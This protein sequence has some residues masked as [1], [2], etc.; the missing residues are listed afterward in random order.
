M[1]LPDTLHPFVTTSSLTF[2]VG[3][4]NS[5]GCATN[6]SRVTRDGWWLDRVGF[7]RC[8]A[9]W[10]DNYEASRARIYGQP[11]P[12]IFKAR[13][14]H[15]SFF[16]HSKGIITTQ[17]RRE[18][19]RSHNRLQSEPAN[20]ESQIGGPFPM[21]GSGET[22]S[23]FA[24]REGHA[25]ISRDENAVDR[26]HARLQL[27]TSIYDDHLTPLPHVRIMS[28]LETHRTKA[29]KTK[30]RGRRQPVDPADYIS[31][32]H[33]ESVATMKQ[34]PPSAGSELGALK[35]QDAGRS[36]FIQT[37]AEGIPLSTGARG[38][39]NR[40]HSDTD[41]LQDLMSRG[42]KDLDHPM[43]C[44]D[45]QDNPS[46]HAQTTAPHRAAFHV[47][48]INHLNNLNGSS[49]PFSGVPSLL[50][51]FERLKHLVRERESDNLKLKQENVILKQIERRHQKDIEFLA[52]QGDDSPRVISALRDEIQGLRNKLREYF[53]N[54]INDSRHIRHLNEEVRHLR[55]TNQGLRNLVADRELGT[56]EALTRELNQTKARLAD[57]E[58]AA[59]EMGKRTELIDKNLSAENRQLRTKLHHLEDEN[60]GLRDNA[61]R[62]E[63]MI[64]D[65]DKEIAS[66]SIYRHNAVH[67]KPIVETICKQ[68]VKRD[69]DD[70]VK[71]WRK[72]IF[73][74]FPKLVP[75]FVTIFDGSK[76]E[77][78]VFLP[79]IKAGFTSA[80]QR[81]TFKADSLDG[82]A[83][84]SEKSNMG[85]ETYETLVLQWTDDPNIS[86]KLT[87][88]V[89][90]KL[91]LENKDDGG[92]LDDSGISEDSLH[93][94]RDAADG[95][96]SAVVSVMS[97][98]ADGLPSSKVVHVRN[99]QCGRHYFFGVV[100]RR[101]GVEGVPC[102]ADPVLVDKLPSQLPKPAV[103]IQ[104]N[105]L[106]IQVKFLPPADG[107]GS[108]PIRF[109]VYHS[110]SSQTD[111][112]VL[113]QEIDGAAAAAG[114]LEEQIA[115][116]E[117]G[118][119]RGDERSDAD[120]E[121]QFQHRI[122]PGRASSARLLPNSTSNLPS[123]NT[124]FSAA[125][126]TT[127]DPS[128]SS[129]V[130][131][132]YFPNFLKRH[133]KDIVD[134]PNPDEGTIL[135]SS[136]PITFWFTSPRTCVPHFFAVSAVNL[137]GEGQK[138]PFS[139]Q[140]VIDFPPEP[141][142]GIPVAK[143]VG[144]ISVRLLIQHEV[145]RLQL[146]KKRAQTS[147]NINSDR[148]ENT[149][150]SLRE[151]TQHS[152]DVTA[153]R[154][155]YFR[156]QYTKADGDDT[157]QNEVANTLG[158]VETQALAASSITG[159]TYS[160]KERNKNSASKKKRIDGPL[161]AP[162]SA[163]VPRTSVGS[164]GTTKQISSVGLLSTSSQQQ[165]QQKS[166]SDNLESKPAQS[167]APSDTAE[168][169]G[170][171]SC[172]QL[173]RE[174]VDRHELV[175][176]IGSVSI[177]QHPVSGSA[178]VSRIPSCIVTGLLPGHSYQ[179]QVAVIN[180]AGESRFSE[181]SEELYLENIP[182][183]S[184]PDYELLSPTSVLIKPIPI[185]KSGD[186]HLGDGA[187]LLHGLIGYRV[188][189]GL[190]SDMNDLVAEVPHIPISV[191]SWT[192]DHLER[193]GST[194]FIS[195]SFVTEKEG[196]NLYKTTQ[197]GFTIHDGSWTQPIR[198]PLAA[199]IPLPPS[200]V[201]APSAET[202]SGTSGE[203][204]SNLRS[205]PP[206]PALSSMSKGSLA[207]LSRLSLN[208]KVE[209]MHNGMP[210]NY[211]PGDPYGTGLVVHA[212]YEDEQPRSGQI[213]NNAGLPLSPV[214][215]SSEEHI[216]PL[217]EGA[218]GGLA[219][220]A[221]RRKT[222]ANVNSV[223][224]QGGVGSAFASAHKAAIR[225]GGMLKGPN[226]AS[227]QNITGKVPRSHQ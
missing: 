124:S 160:G 143:R 34:L 113:I 71:K 63:D 69:K 127:V 162:S 45:L 117:L 227:L 96:P 87:E 205:P 111:S 46:N 18:S 52:T 116:V 131:S 42:A 158:D 50:G 141:I 13:N 97:S 94:V 29:R 179:F 112:P 7:S 184:V 129:V 103:K 23:S 36:S 176:A 106:S 139:D 194:L 25:S 76:A 83:N 101:S 107:D 192:M 16:P 2:T 38:T 6:N 100:L 65:K 177:N 44:Y 68:C 204:E 24:G 33:E 140:V 156:V 187:A 193:A 147:D 85:P 84:F 22:H 155:V 57:Q 203:D 196:T 154:V 93:R 182:V 51:Q 47:P 35:Q 27:A 119:Q 91:E 88:V 212:Q 148:Q 98:G 79:A 181:L 189:L 75:P 151:V 74:R 5:G 120:S 180:N 206:A 157:P 73:A 136:H 170:L 62:L 77:V 54:A 168:K 226:T 198:V 123:M 110:N 92:L 43:E 221:G 134:T 144:P 114:A 80:R 122:I 215:N 132:S 159:N 174:L 202:F 135:N 209:N 9:F 95:A 102:F 20:S 21:A 10:F 82:S 153:I 49:Q 64:R 216:A 142:A 201:D 195:I 138:S 171:P 58:K 30:R 164:K 152:S 219:G 66:L 185:G 41:E 48:Q 197:A 118:S 146:S 1:T 200:P 90:E 28:K 222:K 223:G 40:H 81:V 109:K 59:L 210:A 188:A 14:N 213:D 208:E 61:S 105:P 70:Q 4:A 17:V 218:G 145:L 31:G 149:P 207:S 104:W 167:V 8:M 190:K 161:T 178:S 72:D 56:R 121:Y 15:A 217:P 3:G 172:P 108:K 32:N 99:L 199:A 211:Q 224:I 214:G 191:H 78:L 115:M 19:A 150:A 186:G 39:S 133:F 130:T 11:G 86:D 175:V 225:Q 163:S 126:G 12:Y 128:A 183:P 220:A 55:E 125:D 53:G 89:V 166:S 37:P 169:S 26:Q 165:P 137:A 173:V 60:Q 67:R